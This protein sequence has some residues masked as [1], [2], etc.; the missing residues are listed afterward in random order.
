MRK[1][2]YCLNGRREF[3]IGRSLKQVAL[4]LGDD[5]DSISDSNGVAYFL[6]EGGR[7]TLS[8]YFY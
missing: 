7:G 1:I 5:L 4:Y 6:L 8:L 2:T 3:T